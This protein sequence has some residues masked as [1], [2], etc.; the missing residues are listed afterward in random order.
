MVA[1]PG[2]PVT[3]RTWGFDLHGPAGGIIGGEVATDSSVLFFQPLE[4]KRWLLEFRVVSALT[5]PDT[6]SEL[7]RRHIPPGPYLVRGGYARRWAARDTITV[8][9]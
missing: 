3:P 6:T 2:D 7:I 9:P 8:S 5:G 1:A 4:T